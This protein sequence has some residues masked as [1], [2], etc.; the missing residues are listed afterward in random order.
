[1]VGDAPRAHTASRR[2]LASGADLGDIGL[3]AIASFCLGEAYHALGEYGQAIEVLRE[4][5]QLLQGVP[6]FERFGMGTIVA[7]AAGTWLAWGLAEQGAFAEGLAFGDEALQIA[8]A[9][10]HPLSVVTASF[11]VGLLSLRKGDPP[12]AIPVLE[13]GL[14]LCQDLEIGGWFVDVA[15]VLGAAYLQSGRLA[16]ALPLL[17]R[18]VERAVSI[19]HI[20]WQALRE[21]WL[22]EAYLLSGRVEKAL[23]LAEQAL[24]HAQDRQERG[25]QAWVLRLLGEIHAQQD[26]LAVAQAETYYR[27][28]LALAEALGMRPLQAHCHR[29]LGTL[30]A[31]IGRLKQA[32]A[33]LSTAIELYRAMDM[34][35]WLPEA[36]ATLTQVEGRP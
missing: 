32:R 25:Y 14:R 6:R 36:E 7:V 2:A 3:Q 29:G 26:S 8:E 16:G 1:M 11:G 12:K 23:R 22:S 10:D 20:F 35:F 24:K 5:L 15:P 21:S 28:A 33:E 34:T 4:N 13:R 19:R 30:Y 27:Q 31:K 9:A 17:E 18:A